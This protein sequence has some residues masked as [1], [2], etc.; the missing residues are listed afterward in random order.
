MAAYPMTRVS[1]LSKA[2][3]DSGLATMLADD[4]TEHYRRD[5]AA[6]TF[7]VSVIHTLLSDGELATHIAWVTANGYGPHTFTLKGRNYSG[8][9]LSDPAELSIHGKLRK[10]EATFVAKRV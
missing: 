1:P 7:E 5:S 10:V 3:P 6:T 4:D 9:L 2:R 8:S